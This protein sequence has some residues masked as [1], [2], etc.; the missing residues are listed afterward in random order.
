MGKDLKGKELGRGLSQRPDGRYMGRAQ[1]AGKPI[2]LYDWK[3]KELKKNLAIAVDEAKKS[4][5]MPGIDGKK[6]TL[7]EWFEEWYSKYKAPILKN[8][9]SPSYKRRFVNYYGVR[10]GTKPLAEI[11]QLHVQTAIADMLEAG[12][13]TKSVREATG[14]LQN[15]I[16]AAIANGL[17]SINPVVGVIIPKCEKV[18]RRVLSVEEQGIFLEYLE[19]TKSW[20]EEMYKFMLL[21]GMRIGEVGGLQWNDIDF[22]SKFI[23]VKRTL[24]YNYENGKK[25]MIL[26]SPKTENSVRKIPFFGETRNILERQM[27][28][29]KKRREELGGRWRQPEEFG[30]LV[31]LTSM[32][33]PIGRYNVESDMRYITSQINDMFRTEALYGATV[34][35]TFERI[36][37]HALR[38]TFATRC[39][40]KGMTPRTVQEIMGHANYN[41][42]VSYTH[43][44]DDIKAKEALRVGDFLQ[45]YNNKE[46]TEY[47]S[48]VGIM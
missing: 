20:Y 1:V 43:V 11:R 30:D 31:F 38:H 36:H 29:I 2:V 25:T 16:E 6:V 15:C 18:E 17:M 7:N 10:I 9:G 22:A 37:P 3:L 4:N 27:E 40:E 41:T 13:S 44:L 19:R 8:G 46:E 45:N 23:C 35:K 32:G 34:Q 21:T 28:K 5:L 12:R 42:T 33:S 39:F 48:L 24:S 47:E 14:I 26:T